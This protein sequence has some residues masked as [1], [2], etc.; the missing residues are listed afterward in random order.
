MKFPVGK[1]SS[2]QERQVWVNAAACRAVWNRWL[3]QLNELHG[4]IESARLDALSA[5]SA[6]LSSKD[7]GAAVYDIQVKYYEDLK[8]VLCAY[9]GTEKF[10]ETRL[11][12]AFSSQLPVWKQSDD[13]EVST[14]RHRGE[15][16]A[17]TVPDAWA[18]Q[19]AAAELAKAVN[20][21]V[22]RAGGKR[23]GWPR[24]RSVRRSTPAFKLNTQAVAFV[25]ESGHHIVMRFPKLGQVRL[26]AVYP[27]GRHAELTAHLS[28]GASWR[29]DKATQ[30][31]FVSVVA[32]WNGV[33]P[34]EFDE[35]STPVVGIDRGVTD[36]AVAS[37]GAVL[38]SPKPKEHTV[39]A[40][41]RLERSIARAHH[42]NS[43]DCWVN[44]QHIDTGC[45]WRKSKGVLENERRIAALKRRHLDKV[46]H[47]EHHWTNRVV[48]ASPFV[49]L[50][51]LAVTSMRRS[52]RGTAEQP[53]KNVAAKRGLNREMS[54]ARWGMLATKLEHKTERAGGA[55][56]RVN[57]AFTSQECSQC[58]RI[59]ERRG[60]VFRCTNDACAVSTLDAD[61]NA[62]VNIAAKGR[63]AL[64][65]QRAAKQAKAAKAA[66]VKSKKLEASHAA[67]A[68]RREERQ[69]ESQ[70]RSADE[71]QAADT[72]TQGVAAR[73]GMASSDPSSSGTAERSVTAPEPFVGDGASGAVK[74]ELPR[75]SG[76][77]PEGT[78]QNRRERRVNTNTNTD[79]D[80]S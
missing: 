34:L 2:E 40:I 42:I 6:D 22:T 12:G 52:A 16:I 78:G 67:K 53:G 32:T 70:Q 63:L 58:H 44:G 7:R 80:T 15:D 14:F 13:P 43:P 48:D 24:F 10:S 60:K 35:A 1:L 26:R 75:T 45:L 25:E 49:A 72:P 17:L 18:M 30:T 47:D 38:N 19:G 65:E 3:A 5:L 73:R 39:A 31:W 54:S 77:S 71:G 28:S 61:H 33:E 27:K 74:R 8:A 46:E 20:N 23:W 56:A 76:D 50:E 57:P 79:G 9:S 64:V 51:D 37:N 68:A 29:Y 11:T 21:H 62:A 36:T 66:A 55:L 41:R 69:R 59:G 4:P